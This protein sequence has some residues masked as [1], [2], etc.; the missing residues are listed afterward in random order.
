MA[1]EKGGAV[2]RIPSLKIRTSRGV[3]D[4][5]QGQNVHY[6]TNE[7]SCFYQFTRKNSIQI[8][9]IRSKIYTG[10]NLYGNRIYT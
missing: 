7:R 5:K 4:R 8:L 2:Y 6:M 1:V 10:Q 3:I 9:F